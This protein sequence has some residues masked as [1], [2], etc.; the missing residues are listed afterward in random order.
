MWDLK[1]DLQLV[2]I[3]NERNGICQSKLAGL[4]PASPEDFYPAKSVG[5]QNHPADNRLGKQETLG[6]NGAGKKNRNFH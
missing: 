1:M 6:R 5:Q 3:H 4:T 2:C